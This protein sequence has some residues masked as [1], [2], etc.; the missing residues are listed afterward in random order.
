MTSAL[1]LLWAK[2]ARF[3]NEPKDRYRPLL[4]HLLDAGAVAEVLFDKC[5]P[6]GRKQ[7][8]ARKAGI[9]LQ[10][11]RTLCVA[12]AAL[13]DVG[14]ANPRFQSQHPHL[15]NE[16]WAMLGTASILKRDEPGHAEAGAKAAYKMGL[17]W[18]VVDAIGGHHGGFR[19]W[20]ASADEGEPQ[21]AKARSEIA[22]LVAAALNIDLDAL[23]KYNGFA[24]AVSIFVAGS[25]TVADWLASLPEYYPPNRSYL[26]PNCSAVNLDAHLASSRAQAVN[27]LEGLGWMQHPS[28]IA[29]ATFADTFKQPARDGQ[30]LILDAVAHLDEPSIVIIEMP[31]GYGK[32]EIALDLARRIGI[33]QDATGLFFALPSRA[34][35]DPIFIRLADYLR[36]VHQGEGVNAQ[37]VHG[38]AA[39][40]KALECAVARAVPE[41]TFDGADIDSDDDYSGGPIVNQWFSRSKRGML[42][43]YAVGTVDQL[44]LAGLRGRH[45]ALR[46]FGLANKPIVII[47]EVHSYDHYML[48]VMKTVLAWLGEMGVSVVLLSA[49]LTE[50]VGR[51]LIDEWTG[52]KTMIPWATY[53]RFSQGFRDVSLAAVSQHVPIDQQRLLRLRLGDFDLGSPEGRDS[54]LRTIAENKRACPFGR[55]SVIVNTVFTAQSL[56]QDALNLRNDGERAFSDHELVLYHARFIEKDREQKH[57]LIEERCGKG[58]TRDGFLLVISTQVLEQSIDVDFDAMWSEPAPIDVLLQ[59]FGREHRHQRPASDRPACY[60]QPLIRIC[61]RKGPYWPYQAYPVL[62]T[63]EELTHVNEIAIPGDVSSIIESVYAEREEDKEEMWNALKAMRDDDAE[64]IDGARCVTIKHPTNKLLPPHSGIREVFEG[65]N[66]TDDLEHRSS[67]RWDANGIR[68][69][70]L[71]PKEWTKEYSVDDL[72]GKSLV[73]SSAHLI[74]E[75]TPF[76]SDLDTLKITGPRACLSQSYLLMLDPSTGKVNTRSYEITYDNRLGLVARRTQVQPRS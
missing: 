36:R 6:N 10:D 27:V 30:R 15:P 1:S 57:L 17:G 61:M 68:V 46:I 31:T 19:N 37:L 66:A 72:V 60:T 63:L 64:R 73:V 29:T 18:A 50:A 56:M 4:H 39:I 21:W 54:L 41:A 76:L 20:R 23:P 22:S 53:P 67:T 62:R 26:D 74:R 75:L 7:Y 38:T 65:L 52:K 48:H 51:S 58:S 43:P 25:V 71:G 45:G 8:L 5:V 11:L 2:S 32:T 12:S 16:I 49:T 40:S 42:A 3:T 47:D 24:R 14:K 69:I 34:S 44:L 28:A 55:V 13:H 9:S 70:V 33:A 35:S 59:R